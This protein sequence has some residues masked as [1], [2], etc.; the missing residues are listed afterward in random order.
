MPNT[1]RLTYAT[2]EAAHYIITQPN[3]DRTRAPYASCVEFDTYYEIAY[4]THYKRV[5]KRTL[6]VT[7]NWRDA[8]VFEAVAGCEARVG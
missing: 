4:L 7:R 8:D 1:L 3:G 5:D 2:G 6:A